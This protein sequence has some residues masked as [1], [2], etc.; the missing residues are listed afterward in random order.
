MVGILVQQRLWKYSKNYKFS[1]HIHVQILLSFQR[2]SESK[3]DGS[4]EGGE[5][6]LNC[7]RPEIQQGTTCPYQVSPEGL[8]ESWHME[9]RK[10]HGQGAS[11]L[12]C[13][14]FRHGDGQFWTALYSQLLDGWVLLL[15]VND[16][17]NELEFLTKATELHAVWSV[18]DETSFKTLHVFLFCSFNEW[19]SHSL[20]KCVPFPESPKQVFRPLSAQDIFFSRVSAFILFVSQRGK[21]KMCK[22][23]VYVFLHGKPICVQSDE[24]K[25]LKCG[26]LRTGRGWRPGQPCPVQPLLWALGKLGEA[27]GEA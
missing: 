12:P 19:F 8:A 10:N 15:H 26:P 2:D 1:V 7:V 22:G 18:A 3:K 25:F 11:K 6:T 5:L 17:A 21:K 14:P 27:S 16:C 4:K 20:L 13:E 23:G 24:E 9:T